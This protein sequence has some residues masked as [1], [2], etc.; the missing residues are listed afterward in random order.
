MHVSPLLMLLW[1]PDFGPFDQGVY[2]MYYASSKMLLPDGYNYRPF[3]HNFQFSG[4]GKKEA[5]IIHF[6]GNNKPSKMFQ[7]GKVKREK[8]YSYRHICRFL[9]QDRYFEMLGKQK[10]QDGVDKLTQCK[11]SYV[12]PQR[13]RHRHRRSS[14]SYRTG[15][16]RSSSSYIPSSLSNA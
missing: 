7:D 6:P 14:S 4:S 10:E 15:H 1:Q 5:V 9:V 8:L 13:R 16:R 12:D 11:P 3:G 2:N